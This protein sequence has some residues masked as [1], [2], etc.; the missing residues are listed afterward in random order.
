[1][2]KYFTDAEYRIL[3]KALQREREVCEKV[4]KDCGEEHKLIHI[5]DNIEEKIHQMQYLK[6]K[7]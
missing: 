6:N 5:M 2:D 3:L 7:C 1:M 4:D